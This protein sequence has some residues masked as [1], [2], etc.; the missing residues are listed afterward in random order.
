[1]T[2][3]QTMTEHYAENYR[4]VVKAWCETT[5]MQTEGTHRDVLSQVKNGTTGIFRYLLRQ[6]LT[7]NS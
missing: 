7:G 3:V 2:M 1:M 5:L 6:A 4:Y